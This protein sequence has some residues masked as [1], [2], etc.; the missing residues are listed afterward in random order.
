MYYDNLLFWG[1][2]GKVEGESLIPGFERP[3]SYLFTHVEFTVLYS[4]NH[5][6]EVHAFSDPNHVVDI[7]EDAEVNVQFTYSA[8]WNA[9]SGQ[10][11]DRMNRYS[12]PSSLLPIQHLHWFSVINSTAIIMLSVG[13]L[14]ILYWWNNRSDLR[15]YS[16]GEEDDTEVGWACIDGDVFGCPP[17]LSLF[18]AILGCGT[19]IFLMACGLFVLTSL[20][21][22]EHYSLGNLWTAVIF[23]YTMTSVIAGYTATS[24]HCQFS[25]AGWEKS[26]FLTGILFTGPVFF[27]TSILSTLAI[28]YG[29]MAAVPFGTIIVML[30]IYS[31]STIP[32][33]ALGGILGHRYSP[34]NSV[35]YSKRCFREIPPFNWYGKIHSQMFLG[36]LLPFSGILVELHL[37][38]ASLWSHKLFTLPSILFITF[39]ILVLLTVV[40]SIGLTYIQL[41]M[42]DSQW[43]WRPVM[44]GGSTAIFMFIYS[45]YFYSRSDMSGVMQLLFFLGYNVCICYAFFLMLGTISFYTSRM[46]IYRIYHAVK[47]E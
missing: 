37:F 36:G 17:F 27:V 38:Y 43:C 5:V 20:G 42:E 30:L 9:T 22:L 45:M 40:L 33:L 47:S 35:P 44:R 23:L 41:S 3:R 4:G 26:V 2:I 6:I 16:A 34:R 21:L 19:Q 25:E 8:N 28:S 14:V 31:F 1:F 11:A 7:T 29:A 18:C 13:L 12:R 15:K 32:L 24:F 39:T 10:F 46:F